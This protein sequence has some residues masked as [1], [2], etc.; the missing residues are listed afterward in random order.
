MTARMPHSQSGHTISAIFYNFGIVISTPLRRIK[1]CFFFFFSFDNDADHTEQ[2]WETYAANKLF[3]R[4]FFRSF[5]RSF[6]SL[7]LYDAMAAFTFS[8][9]FLFSVRLNLICFIYCFSSLFMDLRCA[10]RT[11]WIYW[12]RRCVIWRPVVLDEEAA[13][14]VGL[15]IRQQHRRHNGLMGRRVKREIN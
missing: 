9:L 15:F 1:C 3:R 14:S 13:T 7:F 2:W 6:A 5:V 11:P 12:Q 4:N 8:V 10:T